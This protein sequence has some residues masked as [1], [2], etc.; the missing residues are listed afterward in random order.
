MS[1]FTLQSRT[2]QLRRPVF[3]V[4]LPAQLANKVVS[5]LA[6]FTLALHT[7]TEVRLQRVDC[8][9]WQ[10]VVQRL[11]EV[12]SA[13]AFQRNWVMVNL[14]CA[15]SLPLAIALNCHMTLRIQSE[16]VFM[17]VLHVGFSLVE[18]FVIASY[19]F[20]AR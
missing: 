8:K 16:V 12:R 6:L 4:N 9:K 5:L 13:A 19:S 7:S 10:N 14:R 15:E 3:V 20:F 2:W 11:N 18:L 17:F 1:N